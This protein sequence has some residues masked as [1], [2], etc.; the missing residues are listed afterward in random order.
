M[1]IKRKSTQTWQPRTARPR[2]WNDNTGADPVWVTVM[3]AGSYRQNQRGTVGLRYRM[4]V[5]R[6]HVQRF[7]FLST[8]H[9]LDPCRT[10][11]CR[12]HSSAATAVLG[13]RAVA[14]DLASS[15]QCDHVKY[16]EPS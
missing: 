12:H 11:A 9:A 6:L 8:S 5:C 16:A 10:R 3:D 4:R 13:W 2:I 7:R 1:P 14:P 15:R